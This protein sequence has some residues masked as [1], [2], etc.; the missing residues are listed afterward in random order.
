MI[1]RWMDVYTA[2]AHLPNELSFANQTMYEFIN[3]VGGRDMV[4]GLYKAVD[5]FEGGTEQV[6]AAAGRGRE[7]A[8]GTGAAAVPASAPPPSSAKPI[9]R[10]TR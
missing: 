6:E 9:I 2:F 1:T 3:D 4:E 5:L 10:Q 7:D 8:G